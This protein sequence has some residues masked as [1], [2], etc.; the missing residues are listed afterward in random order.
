MGHVTEIKCFPAKLFIIFFFADVIFLFFFFKT[1]FMGGG[2]GAKVRN[3]IKCLDTATELENIRAS[4]MKERGMI[5]FKLREKCKRRNLQFCH[6]STP[7]G[8][9]NH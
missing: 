3:R 9:P 2:G 1:T 6:K 4:A 8:R 7:V 5:N